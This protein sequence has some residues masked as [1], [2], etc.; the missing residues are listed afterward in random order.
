[1]SALEI[2]VALGGLITLA[3]CGVLYLA[4]DINLVLHELLESYH[5][6]AHDRDTDY[7]ID[8]PVPY[9]LTDKDAHQ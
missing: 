3:L 1:M 2:Q 6:D 5:S 8:A 9:A 4:Y 7:D